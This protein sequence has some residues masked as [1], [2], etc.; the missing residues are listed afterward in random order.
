[1]FDDINMVAVAAAAA[2]FLI[3]LL[4][5]GSGSLGWDTTPFYMKAVIVVA[6]PIVTYFAADKTLE[7]MG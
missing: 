1:M 4:S 7:R 5:V 2:V 6:A 3:A